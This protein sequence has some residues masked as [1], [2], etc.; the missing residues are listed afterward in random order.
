MQPETALAIALVVGAVLGTLSRLWLTPAFVTWSKQ[1]VVEI[2]GNGLAAFLIPY[3][4]ALPVIGE[5]LDV[6]KLPPVAAGVVMY[7]IASGSGD[8]LGNVRKKITG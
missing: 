2:I 7:F 6:S 8:F 4:G 1:L 3:L 5:S